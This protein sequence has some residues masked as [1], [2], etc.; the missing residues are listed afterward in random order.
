MRLYLITGGAG[1][2]GSSL[3]EYLLKN[4]D[5][6]I[7]IDNFN[8]FYNPKIKEQNIS[9][10]SNNKNYVLERGDIRDTQFLNEVFSK[11]KIDVIIHLAA[12]ASVTPSIENPLLYQEVNIIGTF[13]I[14]EVAKQNNIKKIIFSSSSSVYGN[15]Q[16]TPFKEDMNVDLPISPYAMTKK[17]GELLCHTYHHLYQMDIIC[18]RFF[19]VYGPKQRPDL[20]IHK[21]VDKLYKGEEIPFFGDGTTQRDYTYIDDIIQGIDGS[22]NYLLNHREIYEIFNLGE[23]QTIA[24]KQMLATI[25]EAI[26]KKAKIKK[27]PLQA[28]DV[29]KTYADISKAKNLLR[30]IPKTDFSKGIEQFIKWYLD[31]M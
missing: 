6:V 5:K 1:F 24:L 2:I 25:E 4:G 23:H 18:L 15:T 31:K 7:C 30:Y 19:T 8:D 14:L 27:L 28:G 16:K 17:S 12:M 10:F 22:I 29:E 26:G 21:F 13:N 11:H 3:S 9:A 20:A